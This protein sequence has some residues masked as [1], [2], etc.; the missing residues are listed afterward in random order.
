MPVVRSH[1]STSVSAGFRSRN[2]PFGANRRGSR[3]KAPW[4]QP[5]CFVVC[6]AWAPSSVKPARCRELG[7]GAIADCPTFRP[8]PAFTGNWI[9]ACAGKTLKSWLS[10]PR[11]RRS[12]RAH[13]H[14][15]YLKIRHFLRCQPANSPL[16]YR[17]LD[18]AIDTK[19]PPFRTARLCLAAG[20]APRDG[21]EPS[22]VRLTVGCSTAELPG[23]S[24][25]RASA[26]M[27][28]S[29]GFCNPL[30]QQIVPS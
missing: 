23:I 5:G 2:K 27:H 7:S 3:Y 6:R 15:N 14:A 16:R 8:C 22:A 10:S 26:P 18:R 21:F 29:R 11:R 12:S 19:K 9:P 30:R 17:C 1:A 20:V 25:V 4:R 13:P 28:R 24:P